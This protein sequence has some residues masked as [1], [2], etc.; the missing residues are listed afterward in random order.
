MLR[1]VE[2]LLFYRVH[3]FHHSLLVTLLVFDQKPISSRIIP[4]LNGFARISKIAKSNQLIIQFTRIH[5]FAVVSK[6]H[7]KYRNEMKLINAGIILQRIMR[8]ELVHSRS[9]R[10]LLVDISDSDKLARMRTETILS[11]FMHLRSLAD[12]LTKRSIAF[13]LNQ[14][15]PLNSFHTEPSDKISKQQGHSRRQEHSPPSLRLAIASS[16]ISFTDR[17]IISAQHINVIAEH[18]PA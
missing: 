8:T 3:I 4:Q 1:I 15:S 13:I 2:L 11:S 5:G 10:V 9:R 6:D 17:H 16:S 18:R 14:E 7:W 12:W